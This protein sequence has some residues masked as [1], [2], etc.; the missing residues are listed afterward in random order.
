MSGVTAKPQF[1]AFIGATGSGKGVSVGRRLRQLRP[2][3]LLFWD[4]RDEY[5]EWAEPVTSVSDLAARLN[6]ARDKGFA[7]RFVPGAAVDLET[8]FSM[9]CKAAFVAGKFG[10]LVFV[11]EELSSV[12][13]PSYAPPA[14]KVISTQ[15]RHRGIHV[16]GCAQ[17]PTNIDKDFLGAC[18]TVR[19][20]QLGYDSD[21][22]TM[23]KE[24]RVPVDLVADLATQETPTGADIRYIEFHRRTRQH[25]AGR[26]VISSNR[27]R[28]TVVELDLLQQS[29]AK[30][31][32]KTGPT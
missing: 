3:R 21:V 6:A 30:R 13:K 28:E 1:E 14:W 7:L 26:I 25:L 5:R 4:P 22:Q 15:G 31:T 32:R 17:R 9:V 23:A 24:L 2:A 20:F 16:L 10:G 27:Q 11:V 12:T 18:T 29:N 8:A 19:C